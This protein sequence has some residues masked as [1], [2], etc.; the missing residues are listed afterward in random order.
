MNIFASREGKIDALC[1]AARVLLTLLLWGGT[2]SF[3]GALDTDNS[4]L[5][6][7]P[8]CRPWQHGELKVRTVLP[9]VETWLQVAGV[10]VP[11]SGTCGRFNVVLEARVRNTGELPLG[12][13]AAALDLAAPTAL[14]PAFIRKV[15]PVQF[16]EVQQAGQLPNL[17]TAFDGR[18]NVELFMGDNGWLLPGEEFGFRLT[19]EVAPSATGVP[20]TP[21]FRMQARGAVVDQQGEVLPDYQ[22]DGQPLQVSDWSDYRATFAGGSDDP[23]E[24]TPLGDCWRQTQQLAAKDRINLTLD[25][26]CRALINPRQLL[27]N[28]IDA[29]GGQELPLGGY[30]RLRYNGVEVTEPFPAGHLVGSSLIFQVI[31]VANH[32]APVESTVFFEDKSAPV[33]TCPEERSFVC[34]DIDSI[35]NNP[36]TLEP[37]HPLF[38]GRP[39]VRDNCEEDLPFQWSD[40]LITY[41]CDGSHYAEIVRTFTASDA[42]GNQAVPCRQH[43]Y[44]DR[45]VVKAPPAKVQ[46][47]IC[48]ADF[49]LDAQG[50]P[51]PDASGY[52]FFLNGFGDTLLIDGYRCDF[53]AAYTD[54]YFPG[55]CPEA[56]KII[57]K[58]TVLDW[59]A[60]QKQLTFEQII[61]VGDFQ[62]PLLSCSTVGEKNGLPDTLTVST[63]PFGCTAAFQMPLPEVKGECSDYTVT[64]AVYTYRP[65]TD[66]FGNPL[67]G[68][69][70]VK[71]D[72]FFSNGVVSRVPPGIHYF[73]YTVTD[74]CGN[75]ADSDPCVFKV[76]DRV[77][78]VAICRSDLQV[79]L[80]GVGVA[81]LLNTDIDEGSRD[82]CGTV[83]LHLRRQLPEACL[84]EYLGS[85]Y[86]LSREDLREEKGVFYSGEDAILQFEQGRYY[87]AWS[88]DAYFTCCDAGKVTEVE[89]RVSDDAGNRNFCTVSVT[90]EDK[91]PPV[92]APPRDL[93]VDCAVT[94]GRD[95][96]DTLV[97]QSLFGFAEAVDNC[98]ATIREQAP[99]VAID[100]C[101]AGRITRTFQ[102]FDR[103]GNKSGLAQQQITLRSFNDY[104]LQLPPDA[105]L[106]Q[107]NAVIADTLQ[108][109]V[110]GCD[111]LSINVEDELFESSGD[112]CYK[113]FRTYRII[114][115][116]EYD[117]ISSP[118]VIGRDEDGD[119]KPGE[120]PLFI[121]RRADGTYLD[122]ND[123][124]S[125]GFLRELSS[126]GYWEYTQI[127]KVYDRKAPEITFLEGEDSFCSLADADDCTGLVTIRFGLGDDCAP[128]EV[129]LRVFFDAGADGT[130]DRQLLPGSGLSEG[131]EGFTV[132]DR[133]PI[134]NHRLLVQATDGCGNRGNAEYFFELVDCKA[135]ALVCTGGLT[136]PLM[137]FDSD[138]DGQ[139]DSARAMVGALDFLASGLPSDCSG[140][141]TVSIN[142]KGETPDPA[143]DQLV[144]TC[145]DPLNE[146]IPVEIHVW[147]QAYNPAAGQPDGTTGG[148][149]HSFCESFIIVEDNQ[150][151]CLSGM[152]AG[153]ITTEEAEP[154]QGVELILSGRS[155]ASQVSNSEGRFRFENLEGGYDYTVTPQLDRGYLNGV[156]TLDL[157]KVSKH[158]LGIERM[159]SPYKIIAADANRSRNVSTLDIIRLRKMILGLTEGLEGNTS[160]RFIAA[161]YTFP[162]PLNPWRE[163][164]PEAISINDLSESVQTTDFIAVKVGDVTGNASLDNLQATEVRGGGIPLVVETEEQELQAG[165]AYRV[166]LSLEDLPA[167]TAFQFTLEFDPSLVAFEDLHYG[168]AGEENVGVF[169]E[170]GLVT[171][172][173]HQP[174]PG[175]AAGASELFTLVLKARTSGRLS[176]ALRLNS[177]RTIA[178]AYDKDEQAV[179]VV[180]AFGDRRVPPVLEVYPN[181]PNPWREQTVI[182]FSLPVEGKVSLRLSDVSGRLLQE[183]EGDFPAGFN[184]IRL[185]KALLRLPASGILLYQLQ[186]AGQ[187]VS[188]KMVL[189]D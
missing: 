118:Q 106:E 123:D 4:L 19:V 26:S 36:A 47:D 113:I 171:V 126:V 131:P 125:D 174:G 175:D 70:F 186:A 22:Q 147:D 111:N 35:F 23:D 164:L 109:V 121:L 166:H 170:E 189:I 37:D 60:D 52:P 173:W 169:A 81:Q 74:A 152:I 53:S 183:L 34:T 133:F 187:T 120:G 99:Q 64:A 71:L 162:D 66:P 124:E 128:G 13:L 98:G 155:A 103:S 136:I 65:R 86:G 172:S 2:V 134:G 20:A 6:A 80:G 178:E 46:L 68:E 112:E 127:I 55:P 10:D 149:N 141:V 163:K 139:V 9:N 180:L 101:G 79:S 67:G 57:R 24:P 45:P 95:L 176:D 90:I 129:Q 146:T 119:G 143:R 182:G 107:C 41:G 150:N 142:R 91:V 88:E 158:I 56:F 94:Q 159:G 43:F 38:T 42:S 25:A 7:L 161:D 89:L 92:V 130:N 104:V 17:N 167:I 122:D 54:Q 179:D 83:N 32:C 148:P 108:Y 49:R 58:W 135:P 62:G 188:G 96:T 156:S 14:G 144:V 87:S 72:V 30:Y 15:G 151:L 114:N 40:E 29:C 16:V 8:D 168:L 31:S 165:K 185:Q 184:E 116:C 1:F 100:R 28:F 76:V 50:H 61:E 138:G 73:V 97:L 48:S 78:P 102:A 77:E 140:P 117:D 21:L 5:T 18:D 93:A 3:S 44:F 27:T 85:I 137:P 11:A 157:L 39:L 75:V 59:C 51:H 160:W 110:N 84:D 63:G 154:V 145:A 177:R 12:R 105:E 132:S 33:I 69:D 115:G 153:L 82:N 181:F